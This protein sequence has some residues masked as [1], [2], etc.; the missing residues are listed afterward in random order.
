M[1]R[2]CLALR[3]L[4]AMTFLSLGPRVR[5]QSGTSTSGSLKK[6][7]TGDSAVARATQ[8]T[9][10][11]PTEREKLRNFAFDAFG[12]YP[13]LTAAGAAGYQQARNKPSDWGQGWDSFGV[14][15]GSDYGIQLVTTAARYA[16]AEAF[17]E[18]T[19]YYRCSRPGFVPRL[20]HALISTVSARRGDD[21][22][23]VFSFAAVAAPYAG[24]MTATLAWYP[25]RYNA[26]DGFRIGNYNLVAAA[27]Q[28]L[29]LEFIYG[30]PHTLLGSV[31][32]P[33]LANPPSASSPQ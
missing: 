13:L 4:V 30:G 11:R 19:I 5:A 2:R 27:A 12:P 24:T 23:R 26:A 32:I 15:F 18:D 6:D 21:G 28:N 9:Y 33:L 7:A 16:V 17:H 20:K 3:L 22:R 31:H 10:H 1:Q 14:R 8:T 25:S 29:A